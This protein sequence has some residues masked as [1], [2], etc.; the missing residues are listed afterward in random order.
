[1]VVRNQKAERMK[2]KPTK[3]L[4]D[5]TVALYPVVITL[6]GFLSDCYRVFDADNPV[7]LDIFINTYKDC[8]ISP[9]AQYANG[10][11]HDYDAVKNSLIYRNISNGPLEGANSRIKMKHRRG[12]GRAGIEL[13]NAY[14]VLKVGDLAR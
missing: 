6:V 1:M 8:D 13:I 3:Q 7:E 11:L 14:N 9:L 10:L 2:K 4:L 12:G 5:E